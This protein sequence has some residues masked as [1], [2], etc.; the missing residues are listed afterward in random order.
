[1]DVSGTPLRLPGPIEMN[2]LRIGQE[3]VAN[4][5]KHGQASRIQ[6]ELQYGPESVIL[7]VDDDGRG[8]NP[9]QASAVGHFGML[10]LRERAV[11][12]GSTLQIDSAP[13]R[14]THIEIEVHFERSST[15]D[16]E[17]KTHTHSGG[18]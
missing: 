18:G 2:L 3:A 7:R 16:A 10:D 6:I 4:A 8:F 5:V 17:I 1:V 14:G 12:L 15:S 13:G 11:S 9:D